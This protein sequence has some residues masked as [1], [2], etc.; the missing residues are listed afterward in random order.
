[1]RIDLGA[2]S[3]RQMRVRARSDGES[4]RYAA[5]FRPRIRASL[6]AGQ[7]GC[8]LRARAWEACL[9]VSH[10]ASSDTP[11]TRRT[12]LLS[13]L[14]G[15]AV[16]VCDGYRRRRSLEPVARHDRLL[17][18]RP[19]ALVVEVPDPAL[20]LPGREHQRAGGVR[21]LDRG[22]HF[23]FGSARRCLNPLTRALTFDL[24]LFAASRD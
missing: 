18:A 16:A 5:D 13:D 9:L 6:A 1:M 14:W 24:L 8:A 11:E 17:A 12:S 23:L 10:T 19:R 22:L 20:D 21:V 15:G 4:R 2:R 3:R 7:K